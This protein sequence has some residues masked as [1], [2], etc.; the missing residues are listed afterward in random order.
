MLVTSSVPHSR[1][2]PWKSPGVNDRECSLRSFSLVFA[3]CKI[4]YLALGGSAAALLVM[5]LCGG[6]Q[7]H[8]EKAEAPA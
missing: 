1:P 7:L 8:L 4:L 6:L 5:H 2:L 3:A